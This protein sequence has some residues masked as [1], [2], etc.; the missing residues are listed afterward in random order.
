MELGKRSRDRFS[1]TLDTLPFEV[2]AII[3]RFVPILDRLVAACGAMALVAL[4][5]G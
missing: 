5:P 4:S 3:M 1:L 2:L